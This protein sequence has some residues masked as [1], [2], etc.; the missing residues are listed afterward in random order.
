M[1]TLSQTA[2]FMVNRPY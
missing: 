2:A 1:N